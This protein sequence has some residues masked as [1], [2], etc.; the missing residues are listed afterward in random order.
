MIARIYFI[1]CTAPEVHI[2]TSHRPILLQTPSLI[3][4]NTDAKSY[5]KT[6]L[7]S[8]VTREMCS[9]TCAAAGYTTQA[10]SEFMFG[11]QG[12]WYL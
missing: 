6:N 11:K 4:L 5:S 7:I 1:V 3:F 12:V 9:E 2:C 10:G 8:L